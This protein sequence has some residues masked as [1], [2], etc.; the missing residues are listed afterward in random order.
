M[1]GG[2]GQPGAA[3]RALGLRR[4]AP[5]PRARRAALGAPGAGWPG[6]GLGLRVGRGGG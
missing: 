3:G 1:P 5:G 4:G 2:E 6:G